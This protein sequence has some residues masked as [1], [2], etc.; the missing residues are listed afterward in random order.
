MPPKNTLSGCWPLAGE[1]SVFSRSAVLAAGQVERRVPCAGGGH[2]QAAGRRQCAAGLRRC[3]V[4]SSGVK[5]DTA[6]PRTKGH[7]GFDPAAT[8]NSLL[9]A[10]I[11]D[12]PGDAA[13]QQHVLPL[14]QE[15]LQYAQPA[16]TTFHVLEHPSDVVADVMQ[17]TRWCGTKKAW[18]CASR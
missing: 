15:L 14:Y 16:V 10:H 1:L 5:A 2:S 18:R 12:L 3:G 17:A 13:L 9:A 11:H 6:I 8:A 4:Q 7:T